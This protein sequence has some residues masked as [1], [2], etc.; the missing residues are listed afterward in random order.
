MS[1]K[2]I[3]RQLTPLRTDGQPTGE[4]Q[5]L[6]V[7]TFD[8]GFATRSFEQDGEVELVLANAPQ[9]APAPAP[10]PET[11]GGASPGQEGTP[12]GQAETPVHASPGSAPPPPSTDG[13]GEGGEGDAD[14]GEGDDTQD[15]EAADGE[16]EET[17]PDAPPQP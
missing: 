5:V 8:S 7:G 17:D 1:L 6:L 14:D 3:C 4:H 11:T 10:P 13:E 9:P 12:H 16:G 15:G 2:F